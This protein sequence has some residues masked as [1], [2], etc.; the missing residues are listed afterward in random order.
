MKRLLVSFLVLGLL[1]AP[2]ARAQSDMD[3]N[4]YGAIVVEAQSG[5]VIYAN[6]ADRM[7]HP[8]SLTKLMTLYITFAALRSG[9]I[10]EDTV[11]NVS[12]YAASASP[13]KLGLESGDQITVKDAIMGLITCSA[14]DAARAL[15]EGIGGSE[16]RFANLMTAQAHRLDMQNTA[17]YN[18]SG[19][20]D[21]RQIS[22][23]KDMAILARAIIVQFPEYYQWFSTQEF[24][25][26]GRLYANHNHLMEHYP[27][28]DGMKTGYV[29][30][31]GFNLVS[32]AVHNGTRLI[33]VVFGGRSAARRDDYM[34]SLLDQSFA[35]AANYQ[36][37]SSPRYAGTILQQP[38]SQTIETPAPQ[39]VQVASA[40]PAGNEPTQPPMAE[41][42][43]ANSG[44]GWGVQIGAYHSKREAARA[45]AH[46]RH[47]YH[48]LHDAPEI[49]AA[50][51]APT[52]GHLYRAQ[53]MSLSEPAATQA[54]TALQSR[55]KSCVLLRP[56]A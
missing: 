41:T 24:T 15:A 23:P 19:L 21:D 53:L 40:A 18:A 14:N 4:R 29:G 2:A 5:K 6:H 7:L 1:A 31:S 13:T 20:P 8:A 11:L 33:G 28:M 30:A 27:G 22:T 56:T 35:M 49:I 16:G 37:H 9:K 55:G 50:I 10:N 36:Q 25:Y 47:Y 43:T 42:R 3:P 34:A 32:S 52:G 17:F 12:S 51:P 46:A 26:D 44:S 38:A 54:C 39:P 45:L 48:N